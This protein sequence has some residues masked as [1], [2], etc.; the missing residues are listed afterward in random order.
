MSSLLPRLPDLERLSV[1]R[2]SLPLP[3][4]PR[5][6]HTGSVRDRRSM[7]HAPRPPGPREPLTYGFLPSCPANWTATTPPPLARPHVAL[8]L[9]FLAPRKSFGR[10]QRRAAR[11]GAAPL[12]LPFRASPQGA[13]RHS[14]CVRAHRVGGLRTARLKN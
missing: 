11:A 13:A 1:Y 8:L 5:H 9:C 4:P 6:A 12:A 10:A 14:S 2:A 3:G 7:V